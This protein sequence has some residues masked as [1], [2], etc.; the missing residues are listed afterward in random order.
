MEQKFQ[1]ME[2]KRQILIWDYVE[3]FYFRLY[4]KVSKGIWSRFLNKFNLLIDIRNKQLIDGIT[5]P[6]C[7]SVIHIDFNWSTST[8]ARHDLDRPFLVLDGSSSL[9]PDCK[10]ET[11]S[12]AFYE[13]WVCRFGVPGK[14]IT[15][16]GRQFESQLFRSLAAICEAKVAHATLSSSMQWESGTV[17]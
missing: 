10:T 7:Y 12:K 6:S 1:P 11:A 8:I 14:I 5:N 3:N 13:H 16:Q 15:D 17:A 9:W 2:L 4:R